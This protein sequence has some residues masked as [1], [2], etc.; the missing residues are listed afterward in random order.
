MGGVVRRRVVAA[1]LS[2]GVALSAAALAAVGGDRRDFQ[3]EIDAACRAG[4][5]RVT[6]PPGVWDTGP[7]HLRSNVELHVEEGAT[8]R[9]SGN[10]SDYLPKVATSWQGEE[11]KNL[12]PLVYAAFATNVAITGRGRLTTDNAAW[13]RWHRDNRNGRRPQFIQFFCCGNVRL[14]DFSVRG[15][16]FWTIH[17]YRTDE[18]VV[19][20]VDVSAFDE[21]GFALKN[22]D[23]IDIECS[24]HV[25]VVGC[26]F[27]QGDDAIVLKSGRDE[28]GIRRGIPTEDVTIE[29][30]RV[31]EGHVLLGIGSEVGGGIRN[32]TMR[33][34]TVEGAVDRL[35]FVKTNAKR[36]GFIEDVVMERVR[37]DR[38]RQAVA[39]LMADYWYYPPPGAA[40]LHR[41]VIRG[42]A[43]RNVRV[44]DAGS[45]VELRGDPD[46]PARDFEVAGVTVDKVRR[47]IV[48]AV[49][50]ENLRVDGLSVRQPPSVPF[51]KDD[52]SRGGQEK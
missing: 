6:V 22:T 43:V 3:G 36:G 46:L 38:V 37:A 27:R 41:T 12:S 4:G 47:K 9:F 45:V 51:K 26:T 15:S 49:N 31:R 42:V 25:K 19:R 33:D 17:L 21:N 24:R 5:G 48:D 44:A 39:A 29:D 13:D 16:P 20:G 30:C 1:L 2:A 34:C 52:P 35:L 32:V 23:G 8:L 10:P 14:E 40:N 18:A 11:M 50:V 28:D 7:I